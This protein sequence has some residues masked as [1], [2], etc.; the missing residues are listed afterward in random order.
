MAPRKRKRPERAPSRPSKKPPARRS[1]RPAQRASSPA[2]PKPRRDKTPA[3][4]SG[5]PAKPAAKPVSR[6]TAPRTRRPKPTPERAPK[7]RRSH[8]ASARSTTEAKK[9]R[10]PKGY[11]RAE[12]RTP[13]LSSAARE[14]LARDEARKR[15]RG[16]RFDPARVKAL[17]KKRGKR[18]ATIERELR[19]KA[20]RRFTEE[21]RDII[22][23][24]E[25]SEKRYPTQAARE[26]KRELDRAYRNRVRSRDRRVANRIR[27]GLSEGER[28]ID[29]AADDIIDDEEIS[30]EH[31]WSI[32]RKEYGRAKGA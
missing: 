5:K 21:A 22:A 8:S 14:R 28:F 27:E 10:S 9:P 6:K 20:E 18:P 23:R 17:A 12:D 4:R 26:R 24:I 32:F 13:P 25:R 1:K 30:D 7:P 11:V 31:F 3:P 19:E 29:G 15:A 2:H 16:L